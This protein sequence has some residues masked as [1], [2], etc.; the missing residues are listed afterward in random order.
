MV[1]CRT[2]VSAKVSMKGQLRSW[3]ERTSSKCWHNCFSDAVKPESVIGSLSS[4]Q[5]RVSRHARRARRERNPTPNSQHRRRELS[6]VS[7][8]RSVGKEGMVVLVG[9]EGG[10]KEAGGE[11]EESSDRLSAI[12]VCG[13]VVRGEGLGT[14]REKGEAGTKPLGEEAT[15]E[16]GS[17]WRAVGRG[18]G[19]RGTPK[20]SP[21]HSAST[22][23]AKAARHNHD[24]PDGDMLGQK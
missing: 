15:T 12:E 24:L 3:G 18:E 5:R 23:L 8:G 22:N 14:V 6:I 16:C 9:E 7:V 2:P 4:Y 20:E 11:L 19:K 1:G 13:V 10:L 17:V 21:Q